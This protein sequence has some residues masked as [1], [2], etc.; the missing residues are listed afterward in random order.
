MMTA[1]LIANITP[2]VAPIVTCLHALTYFKKKIAISDAGT[3]QS[4]RD[5]DAE[6]IP[7][8]LQLDASNSKG[9]G[10]LIMG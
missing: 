7:V 6:T 4:D 10:N 9:A 3:P 5:L 8:K 1:P 2:Y